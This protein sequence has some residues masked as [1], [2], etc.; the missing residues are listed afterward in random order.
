[1]EDF[2]PLSSSLEREQWT[3]QRLNSSGEEES[4]GSSD[5]IRSHSPSSCWSTDSGDDELLLEYLFSQGMADYMDKSQTS[6]VSSYSPSS[7]SSFYTSPSMHTK[8]FACN[9]GI[10]TYQCSGFSNNSSLD[11]KWSQGDID[12]HN[13]ELADMEYSTS[14]VSSAG[15]DSVSKDSASE[16]V[17]LGVGLSHLMENQTTQRNSVSVPEQQKSIMQDHGSLSKPYH[18]QVAVC[19][20]MQVKQES[21]PLNICQNSSPLPPVSSFSLQSRMRDQKLQSGEH[22]HAFLMSSCARSV[23]L[24]Q[25]KQEP[26]S[27]I[28]HIISHSTV[29][30]RSNYSLLAASPAHQQPV[31]IDIKPVKL[32]N[33]IDIKPMLPD[34]GDSESNDKYRSIVRDSTSIASSSRMASV[35]SAR[36][37]SPF[38]IKSEPPS[39]CSAGS[40]SPATPRSDQWSPSPKGGSD[41]VKDGS[42]SPAKLME[43]LMV[44][45]SPPSKEE[46][47]AKLLDDKIHL[48]TYPGCNKMYSKSSHLKAHLRRHTGEK[49]FACTWA[50]CGWRF[51]RSD[52]L[53][54]HRRSHSGVKPYQCKTCDK[55][56]SRSDH[57]AK[58]L[59][60]HRKR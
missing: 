31:V 20:K 48:C 54:R 11:S 36:P 9:P 47:S 18:P 28:N 59:K 43:N 42:M 4:D 56:F 15:H 7:S 53:A 26:M 58:H 21:K 17:V 39:P 29:T 10:A 41:I 25:I 38:A 22:G 13:R 55:R 44:A 37:D 51:S 14:P 45:S 50:G 32:D 6:S 57:L 35:Y 24:N 23:K 2:M 12:S 46:T 49:P 19:G 34:D 52:E 60:V 40:L 33:V 3:L 8:D 27:D 5:E 16:L 30:P 1:M